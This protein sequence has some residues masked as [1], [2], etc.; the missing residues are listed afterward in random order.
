MYTAIGFAGAV[1]LLARLLDR[2]VQ[3]WTQ[4]SR[5]DATQIHPKAYASHRTCAHPQRIILFW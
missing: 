4:D 1:N 5:I 2:N 3:M